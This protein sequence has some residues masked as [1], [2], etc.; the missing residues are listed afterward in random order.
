MNPVNEYD[1]HRLEGLGF[2]LEFVQKSLPESYKKG[3]TKEEQEIAKKE[4]KE[5][6]E[7]AKG[8]KVSSKE[9]Y[10]DWESDKRFRKRT[11]EI[12]KSEATKAFE[13]MFAE[14][15]GIDTALQNKA[16]KS[17]IPLRVLR[18]VYERGMAA[19]RSGHRPGV[20]PQQWALGR[21][22][23]F[24]TG[25]GKAREAD[26]DLWKKAK[27][28]EFKEC[29]ASAIPDWKQCK[30]EVVK[31]GAE[32][33]AQ[34]V[35]AWKTGKVLGG[36]ISSAL[37]SQYGIPQEVSKKVSESVV[38]ALAATALDRKH[39]HDF[40][41]FVK[42]V[43]VEFA[44][45]IIGKSAHEGAENF[46][47]SASVQSSLEHAL[48]ILSGKVAGISTAVAGGKVPSPAKF[49]KLLLERSRQDTM[50]LLQSLGSVKLA[51]FSED[52]PSEE[53]MGDFALMLLL[54]AYLKN[55]GKNS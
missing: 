7:K 51:N 49:G 48:P 30:K 3:L 22:N 45:A 28:S 35:A 33:L 32:H 55:K 17:G 29:G 13:R 9:L 2:D 54:Q 12:P 47:S 36:M 11:K 44:A 19:W 41:D 27:Y 1:W 14:P 42:K 26:A 18:K 6:M 31:H 46:L 40:D 5:T 50:R 23:S 21:V 20:A 39:L 53:Y 8:S 25:K 37:E 24:I 43:S 4:A 16:K 10:K 15:S 52:L 34:G 38:Q